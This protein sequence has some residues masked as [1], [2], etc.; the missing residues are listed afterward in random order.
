M[1][2][3]YALIT[4]TYFCGQAAASVVSGVIS[5]QSTDPTPRQGTLDDGTADPIGFTVTAPYYVNTTEPKLYFDEGDAGA[6]TYTFLF[7]RPVMDFAVSVAHLVNYSSNSYSAVGNFTLT[8]GDGTIITDAPFVFVPD[9]LGSGAS[10]PADSQELL[11]TIALNNATYV[12]D[13]TSDGGGSQAGAFIEF[14]GD[15]SAGVVEFSFHSE[16]NQNLVALSGR[17]HVYGDPASSPA[18][19]GDPT[20]APAP[21]PDLF[22]EGIGRI[23]G[24]LDLVGNGLA[25]YA[26]EADYASG[27][28]PKAE[29][30]ADGSITFQAQGDLSMG[31]FIAE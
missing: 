31:P 19:G 20:P 17:M 22:V 25:V 1:K 12:R 13:A 15:L 24:G 14:T 18:G 8:L 3:T 11:A 21:V 26:S 30:K 4:L 6:G 27:E 9:P 23:D 10:Y 29:I 7:D 2:I 16:G 28:A 5:Q